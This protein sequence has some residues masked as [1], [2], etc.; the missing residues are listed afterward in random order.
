MAKIL[1][2]GR[3]PAPLTVA[4]VKRGGH[5]PTEALS[6]KEGFEVA[7]TLP[8]DSI[9]IAE[10][11]NSD[12]NVVEFIDKLA[13][14]GLNHPVIV[15]SAKYDPMEITSVMNKRLFAEFLQ[16]PTFDQ[17]LL[18]SIN[19]HLPGLR[20]REILPGNLFLQRGQA[21]DKLMMA[22]GMVGPLEVNVAVSGEIGLGK[23]RIVKA[24]HESS[25]R[26]RKPFLMVKH[27]HT[28]VRS[29]GK[30]CDH[31][32]LE[33]CF[34]KAQGGTL[35]L[36]D[37]HEFC[38]KGQAVL[39]HKLHDPECDVRLIVSCNEYKMNTRLA[40]GDFNS[41]LWYEVSQSMIEIP[42]LR[43]CPDNIEWLAKALLDHFCKSH[44]RPKMVLTDDALMILKACAWPGNV[45][46]LNATL[47]RK[48]A[49]CDSGKL[50]GQDLLDLIEVEPP[51][52][53]EADK[54]RLMRILKGSPSVEIAAQRYGKSVRTVYNRMKKYNIDCD[55]NHREAV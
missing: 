21:A 14:A 30:E 28:L 6:F 17:T 9:I 1:L 48:A 25:S 13:E 41:N 18:D 37:I 38:H 12:G 15:H 50:S 35:A 20:N 11:R 8:Y 47:L 43:E 55:G 51:R 7:K 3:S 4:L 22:L 49:V 5:D 44:N 10:Y 33:Q 46:Q 32:Y 2:I 26:C 54:E 24:I 31:C 36:I 39:K 45:V 29:C 34:K 19:E 40:S 53:D 42:P 27:D 23:E 16:T 52:R